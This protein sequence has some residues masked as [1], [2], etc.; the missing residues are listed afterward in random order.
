MRHVQECGTN[1]ALKV[2]DMNGSVHAISW[3]RPAPAPCREPPSH[4]RTITPDPCQGQVRRWF[5]SVLGMNTKG[6]PPAPNRPPAPVGCWADRRQN[7]GLH[8]Q[9]AIDATVVYGRLGGAAAAQRV[10]TSAR[11]G[12]NTVLTEVLPS[13]GSAVPRA[14]RP[15][16]AAGRAAR[17]PGRSLPQAGKDNALSLIT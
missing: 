12:R 1:R 13:A 2:G 14:S 9:G 4:G 10:A 6:P 17:A 8:T 5:G 15:P 16:R 3:T 7:R 11:Q